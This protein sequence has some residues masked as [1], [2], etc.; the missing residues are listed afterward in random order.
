MAFAGT[1]I[2]TGKKETLRNDI[3]NIEP[4]A[5]GR[6]GR[7]PPSAGPQPRLIILTLPPAG[8]PPR[9]IFLI[10]PPAGPPPRPNFSDP[11]PGGALP[12]LI[13]FDPAPAGAT[14]PPG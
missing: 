11:G 14:A 2:F 1:F 10:P 8:S 13:Y 3:Q 4:L 6:P 9:L 12:R 7:T 5:P